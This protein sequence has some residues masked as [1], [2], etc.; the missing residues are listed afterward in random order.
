MDPLDQAVSFDDA[1]EILPDGLLS[2]QPQ[3]CQP[4]CAADR[5][6]LRRRFDVNQFTHRGELADSLRE[7]FH[8][9]A[10]RFVVQEPAVDE[11]PRRFLRANRRKRKWKCGGGARRQRQEPIPRAG[12]VILS[13]P[14]A[15]VKHTFMPLFRDNRVGELDGH[16]H[17]PNIRRGDEHIHL[18]LER[19][20]NRAI[21]RVESI[22]QPG[23]HHT[24]AQEAARKPVAIQQILRVRLIQPQIA[25]LIQRLRVSDSLTQENRVDAAGGCSRGDIDKKSCSHDAAEFAVDP[26]GG[27]Q[28][29]VADNQIAIGIRCRGADQVK[30]LQR[31]SVDVDRE[32]SS[33]IQHQGKTNVLQRRHLPAVQQTPGDP[34]R[35]GPPMFAVKEL[36]ITTSQ[37]RTSA[38]IAA[39]CGWPDSE[40]G[41]E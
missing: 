36:L 17:A 24:A 3:H 9:V 15:Q 35:R 4:V 16:I 34:Q 41:R 8:G 37:P 30:E 39:P 33:A 32:R 28:F 31:Y 10:E 40:G 5:R 13:V 25:E 22:R 11:G 23:M 18:R 19:R 26:L 38:P 14:E 6:R 27:T 12:K 1:F 21:H 20:R 29:R 7:R 2:S